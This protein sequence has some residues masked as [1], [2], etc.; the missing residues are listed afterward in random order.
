MT[1]PRGPDRRLVRPCCQ[2]C[3]CVLSG[4]VTAWSRTC[5]VFFFPVST[6]LNIRVY[7][8]ALPPIPMVMSWLVSVI[9]PGA[10]VKLFR[11]I[12]TPRVSIAIHIHSFTSPTARMTSTRTCAYHQQSAEIHQIQIPRSRFPLQTQAISDSVDV[13]AS[14]TSLLLPYLPTFIND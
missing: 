9:V 14:P 13:V 1:R 12:S 4:K 5:T 7:F 10:E 2:V 6:F 8:Y 3:S 11:P